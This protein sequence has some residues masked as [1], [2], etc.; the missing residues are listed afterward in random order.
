M[1]F[2]KNLLQT[3]ENRGRFLQRNVGKCTWIY[4]YKT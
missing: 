2:N 3:D 1:K 4:F